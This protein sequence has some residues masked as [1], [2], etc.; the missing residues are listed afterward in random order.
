VPNA[1]TDVIRGFLERANLP[2]E[3]V[4]L[5]ACVLEG[6]SAQFQTSWREMLQPAEF[7]RDLKSF[8]RTD[9]RRTAHVST[10]III[11]AALAL[12]HGFQSDHMRSS[13]H[14]SVKESNV[15]FSVKEIEA[16]KRAILEDMD[17]GLFRI[18]DDAVKK[19]LEMMQK[20]KTTMAL[21]HDRRRTL[22]INL[23]GTAIWSHG[24]QTPEPSP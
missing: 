9:E 7:E 15:M 21:K 23:T 20:P 24:V 16:T 8:L 18:K 2:E 13:R 1:Q 14:W 5:A 17:Y 3:V 10:N 22:S 4:A 19:M 11:L 12:A 6:L